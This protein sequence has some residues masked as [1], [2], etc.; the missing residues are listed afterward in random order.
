MERDEET[1][2]RELKAQRSKFFD[3]LADKM[4]RAQLDGLTENIE[5]LNQQLKDYNDAVLKDYPALAIAQRPFNQAVNIRMKE[6]QYG[7]AALSAKERA[8]RDEIRAQYE[9]E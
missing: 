4:A 6:I 8:L 1:Q 3:H 2:A 7:E 9:A 5:S